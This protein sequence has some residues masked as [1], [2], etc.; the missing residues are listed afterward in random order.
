MPAVRGMGWPA[1]PSRVGVPKCSKYNDWTSR[2]AGNGTPK[3]LRTSK[4]YSWEMLGKAAAKSN[5]IKA[6]F[7]NLRE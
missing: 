1:C 7:S 5:K 2:R 6:G 3:W 4:R